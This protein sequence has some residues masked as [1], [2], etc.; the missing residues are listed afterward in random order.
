MIRVTCHPS[1]RGDAERL[2]PGA[3]IT[4]DSQ[5]TTAWASVRGLG[6][7]AVLDFT[8]GRLIKRRRRARRKQMGAHR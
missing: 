4:E 5:C 3:V 8:S 6:E 1:R 7:W 2:L